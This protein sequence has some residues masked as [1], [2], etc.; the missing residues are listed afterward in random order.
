VNLD[1][2]SR[3][4]AGEA[5]QLFL[6][7]VNAGVIVVQ[8]SPVVMELRRPVEAFALTYAI[9]ELSRGHG[10]RAIKSE[11]CR[12]A[13][14]RNYQQAATRVVTG[15]LPG[16]VRRKGD[17]LTLDPDG[18]EAVR[19]M[20]SLATCLFTGAGRTKSAAAR[21]QFG[22]TD[23]HRDYLV[24][25]DPPRSNATKTGNGTM[26]V[27]EFAEIGLPSTLD[28]RR[29]DHTARLEKLLGALDLKDPA[30]VG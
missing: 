23:R 4:D 10:E 22:G 15:R 2:L 1:R 5:V 13:W 26:R 12:A 9:M 14:A 30:N 20:F 7:I 29:P 19:R 25:E 18:A 24:V 28:L 21:V 16:W 11:R 6:T 8:L 3:E 27:A 17:R